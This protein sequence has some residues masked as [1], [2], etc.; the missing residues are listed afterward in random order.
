[1]LGGNLS[2]RPFYNERAVSIAVA[3]LAGAT[4]L[5]TVFNAAELIH[6]S[7]ARRQIQAVVQRDQAEATR[8]RR[9]A[10]DT[11]REAPRRVLADVAAATRYANDLIDQR[12]F[13]WT[14]FFTVIERTL[15]GDVRLVDVSPR[16]E[17]GVF[18]VTMN[19]I[20][21]DLR[22]L[23]TFIE[24]LRGAGTF[25]EVAAIDQQLNDDDTYGATVGAI[26]VPTGQAP[27]VIGTSR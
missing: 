21:R 9:E 3:V 4:V 8:I 2:T 16:V 5:M 6:L 11:G 20:A 7:T 10:S 26:Y 19:V 22:A 27:P 25:R 1:M 13:S 17:Q 23:G 14:A 15:P 18:R 24:A 12:T